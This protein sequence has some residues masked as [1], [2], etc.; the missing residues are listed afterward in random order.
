MRL[1]SFHRLNMP[2]FLPAHATQ[3][4][5]D[6]LPIISIPILFILDSLTLKF[7]RDISPLLVE[8]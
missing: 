1:V 7:A 8:P 6:M 5:L 4:V 2:L 3:S